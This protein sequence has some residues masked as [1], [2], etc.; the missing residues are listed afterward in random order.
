MAKDSSSLAITAIVERGVLNSCAAP[1]ASV[2]SEA[3]RSF[4][5]SS[6]CMRSIDSSCCRSNSE[7]LPENIATR[8][9]ATPKLTHMPIRCSPT[10]PEAWCISSAGIGL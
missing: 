1:A 4:L 7:I 6:S 10:A 8:S 9:D 3:S 2:T 5:A